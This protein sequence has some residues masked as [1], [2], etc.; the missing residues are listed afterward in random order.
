MW[1]FRKKPEPPKEPEKPG[2]LNED[3]KVGDL[4]VAIGPTQDWRCRP[5]SDIPTE[6]T[7]YRVTSI[8]IAVGYST[9]RLGWYLGLGGMNNAYAANWFKKVR[10]DEEECTT[11]FAETIK[12]L[13]PARVKT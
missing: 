6:G 7:T 10:Q 9:Q 1:A 12:N 13:K 5:G 8:R 11:E 3:W 2:P 4:A